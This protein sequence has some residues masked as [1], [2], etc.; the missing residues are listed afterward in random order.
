M[1]KY[2]T[3]RNS[4]FSKIVFAATKIDTV[5]IRENTR[6]GQ[7]ESYLTLPRQITAF[8]LVKVP[9][10]VRLDRVQ[11]LFGNEMERGWVEVRE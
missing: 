10:H 6:P 9:K 11:T 3:C 5:C 4:L 1:G 2:A 7:H 8:V